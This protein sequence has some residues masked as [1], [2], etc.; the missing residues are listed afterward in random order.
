MHKWVAYEWQCGGVQDVLL[1]CEHPPTYTAGRGYR[2]SP[3]ELQAL[4]A[5]GAATFEVSLALA[6][7][8]TS[9]RWLYRAGG[10]G[11]AAAD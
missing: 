10:L 1:L 6:G 8:L 9:S 11:C 5:V 2:F 7:S 3:L 4:H